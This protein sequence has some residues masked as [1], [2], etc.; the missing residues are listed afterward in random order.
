[1]IAVVDDDTAVCNSLK[2]MLEIEGYVT[3]TYHTPEGLL[4]APDLAA[5]NC[6]IVDYGL[7]EMDGLSLVE[8]LRKRGFRWP[9]IL[10]VSNPDAATHE[11]AERA[12]I[13]LVEKPLLGNTL[14]DTLR[15]S[16]AN[17]MPV[18]R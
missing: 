3:R 5:C 17:P 12:G 7:P 18:R 15:A 13:P 9:A 4:N 14:I 11:R 10:I 6:A 8:V 1:M 16:L 2:F